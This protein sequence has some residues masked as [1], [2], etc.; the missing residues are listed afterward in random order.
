MKT[1][2][3]TGANGFIGSALVR[4]WRPLAQVRP[5]VRRAD[6]AMP[7]AVVVG[8]V[9]PQ[10]D[11]TAALQGADVV[12][13]C[14]GRAH[15]LKE[16][17]R[18]PIDEFRRVNR[19]GALALAQAAAEGGTRR[20]VFLSSIGVM[21]EPMSADGLITADQAPAPIQNYAVSKREAEL[22][23]ERIGRE[24]GLEIVI[25]RP[26]LVYGPGAPANFRRLLTLVKSGLPL[27]LALVRARRSFIGMH[28]LADVLWACIET[29]QAAGGSFFVSDG[30]DIS[31]ADL[32]RR[33]ASHMGRN[34]LLLPVPPAL[35]TLAGKLAGREDDVA[36][37]LSPLRVDVGP[38]YSTLGWRPRHSI[39]DELARCVAAFKAGE[40]RN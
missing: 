4:Q 32:I 9:G 2:A 1:V 5:I 3:V 23:L 37:L 25:V 27:P 26:P 35:L 30:E 29:P 13:H 6:A 21:G 31:T 34:T 14:A 7:D 20:M 10:T 8:D 40:A 38:T 17:A 15:V 36:R 19:D 16:T 11:W 24:T 22:G 12:V 33:I 28:N 39:D 18:D